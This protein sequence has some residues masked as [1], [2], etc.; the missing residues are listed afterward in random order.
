MP[1]GRPG[2]PGCLEPQAL[3]ARSHLSALFPEHSS[4][5][6]LPGKLFSPM[7]NISPSNRTSGIPSP[8]K[9]G[10]LPIVCHS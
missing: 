10:L 8:Q 6:R 5:L 1:S 7:P 4:P 2:D 3:D 9:N